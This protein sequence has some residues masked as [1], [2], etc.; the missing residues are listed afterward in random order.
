MGLWGRKHL[1]HISKSRAFVFVVATLPF[2]TAGAQRV[3]AGISS[4]ALARQL[5]YYQTSPAQ[6]TTPEYWNAL[7]VLTY[8]VP[9]EV[10][11]AGLQFDA[12]PVTVYSMPPAT[13]YLR[14][15]MSPFY[16][17][18]A[19]FLAHF[20]E[21]TYTFFAQAPALQFAPL[22]M[23]ANLY[24]SEVPFFTGDTFTRFQDCN[25]A[26]AF[27][28]TFNGF[29][30][31][32]GTNDG[33]CS[34]SIVQEGGGG[35]VFSL[36]L[37]PGE[38][39]FEIPANT[40]LPDTTY[41]I[42]VAYVTINRTLNAGFGTAASE[43][44]FF[45]STTS[46]FTTR[47]NV[48]CPTIDT[49]PSNQTAIA[50]ETATFHVVAT[51][52]APLTYQ[53]RRG[54]TPLT[55]CGNI[56]GANTATLTIKP[57]MLFDADSNY[58]A[59]VTNSCGSINSNNSVLTVSNCT[60]TGVISAFGNNSYGQCDI[61]PPITGFV[62]IA[63]DDHLSMGLMPD[64]S[65]VAWGI[66]HLG[67]SNPPTP[68]SG[69]VAISAN[70][71]HGLG[72]KADGSIVAWG[73][74]DDGRCD[75]PAPN[76]GFVAVS[77]GAD[78]SLGLKVDGSIVAW[79]NSTWGQGT[80]PAP[81][82]DFV[83]ISAGYYFSLALRANGSIVGFG[84]NAVGQYTV[85]APNS[86]FVAVSAGGYH[87]LGL[88]ADGSIVAWGSNSDGQ[89][90][91][92][93]LNSG[94][95]AVSAGGYHSLG[96]KPDGSIVAW[97]SNQ[98]GQCNIP[99]PNIGYT[100]YTTGRL[101]TMV[102]RPQF[103]TSPGIVTQPPSQFVMAG[104]AV[105]FQVAASGSAP[106][107]YQWRRGTTPLVDG[108][109][110]TGA[111][112]AML[113]IDSVGPS[114]SG[115]DYNVV[116][117]NTCGSL[118]SNDASLTVENCPIAG[119]VVGW[120]EN[121]Y[122]ECN[123]PAPNSEFVAIS[124]GFRF[125]LGLR[126]NGKI[127]A[128]G[129]NEDYQCRVPE[130]NEE[131]AGV[132]AGGVHG[133]GLKSN[134]AIVG[135]GNNY[136]GQCTVPSPNTNFVAV[137]AAGDTSLG[138]KSNG[139][140]VGWGDNSFGQSNIPSPNSGFVAISGGG[141]HVLGLKSDGSIAAWGANSYQQCDVPLPNANFVAISAGFQCSLGL[142]ADGSI[143]A[144]GDNAFGQCSVPAPNSG[145]IAVGAGAMHSVG[146]KS[147]GSVVAWGSNSLGQL[148]VPTINSGFAK[149][150]VGSHHSVALRGQLSAI[151]STQ[152]ASQTATSGGV[153]SF[154]VLATGQSPLTYEWRRGTT[155]LVNAGNISGANTA[156]LTINPAGPS[157]A[158]TDYY[159]VVTNDCGSVTSNQVSLTVTQNSIRGDMNCDGVVTPLDIPLFIKAL[160]QDP[161]FNGCDI[162]RADL[163]EDNLINGRDVS[164]FV[165]AILP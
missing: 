122:G 115:A 110:I 160:L 30:L 158:A 83:A 23:P 129:H 51:S 24:S 8:E 82:T 93:G 120:G 41:S 123:A 125:A 95:V 59:V 112:S 33:F 153:A 9:D 128:W 47:S 145:F 156:T 28:A 77:A 15:Y 75:V 27:S 45:R 13:P 139:S 134:G 127:A 21:T 53:W 157:D 106:F 17:S 101:H 86:N 62:A 144:W 104:D 14:Q 151:I 4:Y 132:A 92:P 108:G 31:P 64:G 49:Q 67:Q 121:N 3:R 150:S 88:K 100:A 35:G 16:T 130:P 142:K 97:G 55:N 140:I 102:M 85:P 60:T 91:I 84:N 124:A 18:E 89:C 90:N 81:N 152:P 40:L 43:A 96:V 126:T 113:H 32:P 154:S 155:S 57:A 1:F 74:N 141:F 42:S 147:D 7:A 19:E 103:E 66:N 29:T 137:E 58:N 109:R 25:S 111:T 133:L 73:S 46:Y 146:L 87:G 36:T 44:Q 22:F 69:F 71:S 39:S 164:P 52:D 68:N 78:H 117:S 50:G 80:V 94:Y 12:P 159:V 65:I 114:D 76:S 105:S 131:F 38:T 5:A 26:L 98:F 11:S 163:N 119:S 61:P 72:L 10:I 79:G 135:W 56:R 48:V 34:I 70:H 99:S 162:N 116:V 118:F 149:L 37:G 165:N 107:S 63:G 136:Y 2:L 20:P 54:E 143:I 138:L 161:S 148:N 6:P